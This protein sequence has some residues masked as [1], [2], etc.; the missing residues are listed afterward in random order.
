MNN[1]HQEYTAIYNDNVEIL[2]I[3]HYNAEAVEHITYGREILLEQ[4]NE[5]HSALCGQKIMKIR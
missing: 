3:R 5:K 4:R 2:T 1:L